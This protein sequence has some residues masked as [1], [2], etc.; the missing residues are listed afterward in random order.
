MPKPTKRKQVEDFILA[1]E[2]LHKR[3]PS[4]KEIGEN[5]PIFNSVIDTILGNIKKDREGKK[6]TNPIKF[7]KAQERHVQAIANI[8]ATEK[9]NQLREASFPRWKQEAESVRKMQQSL[10]KVIDGYKPV[11]TETEFS[12]I[13]RCLHPD[14]RGSTTDDLLKIAFQTFM[15]RK[16]RLLTPKKVAA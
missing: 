13:M 8:I 14:S 2:A 10:E 5:I 7:T 6:I 16:E 4:R 11:F 15:A 9:A 1:Y 3:L 12:N